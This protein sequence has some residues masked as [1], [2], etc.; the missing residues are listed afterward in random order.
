MQ[1]KIDF[2]AL[3]VYK[4]FMKHTTLLDLHDISFYK[5]SLQTYLSNFSF[6]KYQN[7]NVDIERTTYLPVVD[8][9]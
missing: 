7:V 8:I 1:I 3:I 9:R 5:N 6:S 4:T 2:F